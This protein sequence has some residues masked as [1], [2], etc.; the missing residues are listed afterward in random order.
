M[1]SHHLSRFS[2]VCASVNVS[3]HVHVGR[4]SGQQRR[5]LWRGLQVGLEHLVHE[6]HVA[7]VVAGSGV[8]LH[9]ERHRRDLLHQVGPIVVADGHDDFINV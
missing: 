5:R 7:E 9:L 3:E 8:V 4:N 1:K 6:V 2:V